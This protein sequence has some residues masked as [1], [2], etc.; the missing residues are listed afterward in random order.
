MIHVRHSVF[1]L[2]CLCFCMLLRGQVSKVRGERPM[3]SLHLSARASCRGPGGERY[4]CKAGK[5]S[6]IFYKDSAAGKAIA[7]LKRSVTYTRRFMNIACDTSQSPYRGR[8]YICWSDEKNGA[9]NQDVFLTYS[10]DGGNNWTEPVLVT[11]RPNHKPQSDPAIFV[12]DLG[13]VYLSYFDAQNFLHNGNDLYLARSTNGGL[14]FTY[15]QL[16]HLPPKTELINLGFSNSNRLPELHW[17]LRLKN[18]SLLEYSAAISDS[19]LD[20][21][22]LENAHSPISHQ[23]TVAFADKIEFPFT[24]S[25]AQRVD[26]AITRPLEPGFEKI[27]LRNKKFKRGGHRLLIDTKKLGLEKGNY[28]LTL[29]CKG[30][31]SYAWILAE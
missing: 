31:N 22:L 6:L 13:R 7:R 14:L 29:Y 25:E 28:I 1:S 10:E 18:K 9:D 23:K 30:K 27:V 3:D 4:S 24:I 21:L 19:L 20:K 12:D 8:I 26:A 17:G 11:Y 5:D 15:Y 16:D 2:L